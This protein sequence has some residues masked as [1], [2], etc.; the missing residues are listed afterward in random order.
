MITLAL[1]EI[2]IFS[3][4]AISEEEQTVEIFRNV[5]YCEV[6]GRSL[7]MD[8][9]M[10]KDLPETPMPVIVW[11]HGGA[12]RAG[13]KGSGIQ[14][15]IPLVQQGFF[16]ASVE[17][18]F[19]QEAKFPAQIEDCKC[20]IRFLRAKQKEY[21]IDPDRI[22]VWGSSAGGHLAALLGTSGDVEDWSRDR[23]WKEYSSRVQAVFDMWGPTNFLTMN[24]FPGK[25]DHDAPD[26]PESQLIGG[27]IQM[28]PKRCAKVNPI[29]YITPDTPP[30]LILHGMKDMAV[31]FDQSVQLY[32]KLREV[33]VEATFVQVKDG[34]HGLP[35]YRRS[36]IILASVFFNNYLRVNNSAWIG[37][38]KNMPMSDLVK[39]STTVSSE[40]I[41]QK[42]ETKNDK[43]EE[44]EE[45]QMAV[46]KVN[47]SVSDLIVDTDRGLAK[48]E[49]SVV[50]DGIV[51]NVKMKCDAVFAK[52]F[53]DLNGRGSIYRMEEVIQKKP[54][55]DDELA[56][57][58]TPSN[59]HF[60]TALPDFDL[61][62][63]KSVNGIVRITLDFENTKLETTFDGAEQTFLIGE[64]QFLI[65]PEVRHQTID[66]FG[67]TGAWWAQHAGGW[68]D[69]RVR[70]ADLLF[71]E[72][73]GIG[74]TQYRYNAGGGI[75]SEIGDPW[76]TAETFEIAQ[77]TYDWS[78]DANAQWFLRAAKKRGV[79]DFIL[80]VN[81][82]PKRITKSGETF[83]DKGSDTNL[84]PE[85][86]E[87]FAQYLAD[88]VKHF[89]DEDGIEFG[90]LSPINEPEWDWS[91]SGQEGCPYTTSQIVDLT[92]M[93]IRVFRQE[94]LETKMLI[95]EAGAWSFIYGNG[96]N[97]ADA[98]STIAD[99]LSVLAVHSY[100]S[101]N[102]DR[103]RAAKSMEDRIDQR[104]WQTEWCEMRGGRDTGMDSA[105]NLVC[106]LHS[107]LTIGNATAWQTWIGVSR[108]NFRDGLI[109]VQQDDHSVI[110]TKRLWAM[111]NFSRYV[112]PGAVRIGVRSNYPKIGASGNGG[113]LVS[114][115][116]QP[117]EHKLIVVAINQLDRECAIDLVV[118]SSEKITLKRANPFI[119]YRTSENEALKKLS[120]V[121]LQ[122]GDNGI[123]KGTVKLA[124][125]SVTTYITR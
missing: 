33:E 85:M 107:D 74:L 59:F 49:L 5:K 22:G 19:S 99:D 125:L 58:Q 26:S 119:P 86:Y 105:L 25:I 82:P 54:V 9:L 13:N 98:L 109:Y 121:E 95:P 64:T 70:I 7:K 4:T 78:R 67:T 51:A 103:H 27:P 89:R 101:V 61:V 68:T 23:E 60:E 24:N 46:R 94:G 47:V 76:R 57:S 108:Y 77:G 35:K 39:V 16:C 36:Q 71:S 90:W 42:Q 28:Y 43:R 1:M 81:S 115:Y 113:V 17:Y 37:V 65:Q 34:G 44:K 122:M 116:V 83:A 8:I 21:N 111:G 38:F 32:D 6:S 63:G 69:A 40:N 106:T 80:F 123:A 3:F 20:A 96:R 14:R 75:D 29:S 114:A 72:D 11:I 92:K 62:E 88:I 117:K 97:Y 56:I 93:I 87:Q 110:E 12:W 10:P 91:G 120:P 104:L 45:Q 66:G 50:A 118:P 55:F 2:L 53:F 112:R 18:R 15:L 48:G 31:P 124:P 79:R 41:V 30:F 84:S 52:L 102:D 73:K 100:W